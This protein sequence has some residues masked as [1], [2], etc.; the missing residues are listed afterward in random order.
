[1]REDSRVDIFLICVTILSSV[2]ALQVAFWG[3]A[4]NP[5]WELRWRG[6]DPGN[7]DWLAAMTTSRT[8][9]ATLTDPDEIELAKGFGRRERRRHSYFDLVAVALLIVGVALTLAGLLPLSACTLGLACY[10]VIRGAVEAWRNRQIRSR[11]AGANDPDT[12]PVR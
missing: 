12:A 6:L 7:R 9:M 11:V 2:A 1:M 8:W 5:T 3:G 10:V 4:D